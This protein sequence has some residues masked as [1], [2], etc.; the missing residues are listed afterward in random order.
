[1]HCLSFQSKIFI[2]L[3]FL[4]LILFVTQKYL[5]TRDWLISAF[6]IVLFG[7]LQAIIQ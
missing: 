2:N 4:I 5:N 3:S 7:Q 1:M 6:Y